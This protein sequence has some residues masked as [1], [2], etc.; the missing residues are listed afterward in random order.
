[1]IR[2]KVEKFDG[3]VVQELCASGSTRDLLFELT[4]LTH[5]VLASLKIP[6]KDTDEEMP[7]DKRIE[8]FC[9]LPKTTE[10]D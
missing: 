1:M 5:G 10:E 6:Q 2:T 4:A 9:D 8:M 3:G 7:M